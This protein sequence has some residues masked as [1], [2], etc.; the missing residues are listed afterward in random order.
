MSRFYSRIATAKI[1]DLAELV[2]EAYDWFDKQHADGQNDL[3]VDGK[4][5]IAIER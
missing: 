2:Q 1:D 5:I 3:N 4:K